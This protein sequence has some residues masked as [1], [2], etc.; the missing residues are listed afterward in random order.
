MLA[1]VLKGRRIFLMVYFK[2]GGLRAWGMIAVVG[3]LDVIVYEWFL[4]FD[5]RTGFKLSFQNSLL[6]GI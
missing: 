3:L 2:Q 5:V 6:K 1:I 4:Y